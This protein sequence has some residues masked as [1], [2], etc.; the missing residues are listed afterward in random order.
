MLVYQRVSREIIVDLVFQ[1]CLMIL[2]F[3]D[4]AAHLPGRS[5]TDCDF[6]SQECCSCQNDFFLKERCFTGR[7]GWW[8][9][10]PNTVQTQRLS[11]KHL[12]VRGRAYFNAWTH[13]VS[14]THGRGPGLFGRPSRLPWPTNPTGSIIKLGSHEEWISS[15]SSI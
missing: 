2:N 15:N 8:Q 7:V 4:P 1:S 5:C 11:N 13:P 12:H 3:G 14:G 10:P 9:Q 6:R